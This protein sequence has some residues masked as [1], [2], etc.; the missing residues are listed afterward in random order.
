MFKDYNK[1]LKTSLKVY[2]FVLL[3]IFIMKL[4]GLDY[5]GLDDKSKTV[6]EIEKYLSNHW[7]IRDLIFFIPLWI[8]EYVILSI[9][10]KDNSKKMVIFNLVLI[11][12]YY[13]YQIHKIDI[14]GGLSFLG[15]IL[16]SYILLI[17]YN[18]KISKD[19]TKRFFKVIAFIL[20]LQI[21]M[22]FTRFHISNYVTNVIANIILNLD[23]TLVLLILHRIYFMKGDEKLCYQVEV[24]SSLLK[25]NHY[26]NLLKNL[27]ENY[28]NFKKY[29]KQDKATIII[30]S[31]FSLIWNIFTLVVVL[32]MA[33]LNDTFIECIFI[34]SSFWLSKKVFGKAFH[35]K[36][37]IGCFILSNATY[38][39]LNRI[40]TPVGISILVPIMLGVGLSYIT[41]KF[42]RKIK[43]LYKGMSKEDFENTILKVV[44][45]N[46]DKY[47][48]CY[49]FFIKKENAISLGYKYNYTEA[50]I[51]KITYRINEKIKAL[52]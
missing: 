28:S 43:P 20:V 38:Y 48:I 21:V 31:I 7:Y 29:N 33:K 42:V 19:I 18:K 22:M 14:F 10:S 16:Y 27:Q 3:I 40:T 34:I 37:M 35:L 12:I 4:I 24:F 47:K 49:D 41:S 15:D 25:K 2:I 5:F 50:G 26:S 51:R 46:S 17:I 13:L 11:P 36:S 23:Y 30:Y 52:N 39:V 8:N 32:F 6:I 1:Y 9:A 45:K 44:D